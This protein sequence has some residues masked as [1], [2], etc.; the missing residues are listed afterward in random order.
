MEVTIV[1]GEDRLKS[2]LAELTTAK[3]AGDHSILVEYGEVTF[4]VYAVESDKLKKFDAA[5]PT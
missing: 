4:Q 2:M 1:V 5:H 3:K